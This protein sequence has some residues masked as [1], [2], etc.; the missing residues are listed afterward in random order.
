MSLKGCE[1]DD[2]LNFKWFGLARENE[3][4]KLCYK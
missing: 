2:I 4:G 1:Q 3:D